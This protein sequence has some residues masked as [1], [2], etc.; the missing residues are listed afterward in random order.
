MRAIGFS[1]LA[2]CET[3]RFSR[4]E[5]THMPGSQTTPGRPVARANAPVRSAFRLTHN[6]GTRDKSSFAA[7]WLAYTLPCRRFTPALTGDDARLGANAGRD[8]FTVTDFHRSFLA[9]NPA[10]EQ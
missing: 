9:D 8:S 4:K 1:P 2:E 3:S 7:Q 5:L 10:H 6:V